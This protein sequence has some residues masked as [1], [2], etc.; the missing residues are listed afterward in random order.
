[1]WIDRTHKLTP[2]RSDSYIKPK[3]RKREKDIDLRLK[4]LFPFF[5][6]LLFFLWGLSLPL[7][8]SPPSVEGLLCIYSTRFFFSW[9]SCKLVPNFIQVAS[10]WRGLDVKKNLCEINQTQKKA[11]K[12]KIFTWEA[13]SASQLKRLFSRNQWKPEWKKRRKRVENIFRD[14]MEC[15]RS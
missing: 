2:T 4:N 12:R 6:K 1:M 11:R 14:S 10:S 8:V 9:V 15:I 5:K 7:Y 3:R 13:M